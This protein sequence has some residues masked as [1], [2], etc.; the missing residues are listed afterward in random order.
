MANPA[1]VLYAV[2]P[3]IV[4]AGGGRIVQVVGS[5]ID[6]LGT[7]Q[8][9]GQPATLFCDSRF[10]AQCSAPVH[11]VGKVNVVVTTSDGTATLT[12]AITYV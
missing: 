5:N 6:P 9:G 10:L 12:N 2:S 1:P 3:A 11:A 4:P 7:I 8:I